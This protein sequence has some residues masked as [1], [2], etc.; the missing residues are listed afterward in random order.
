[1]R[2]LLQFPEGLKRHALE[3]AG[4]LE[5]D[6]NEVFLLARATYGACDLPSEEAKAL[7]ADK[8]VHFGHCRFGKSDIGIPV[9]YVPFG[10]RVDVAVLDGF[11][12]MLAE[13]GIAKIGI[14]TTAQHI[15]QLDEMKALFAKHGIDAI[16]KRGK[17]S[18]REGQVLGCDA[19]ALDIGVD[20]VAIV[21]DGMFHALAA[22]RLEGKSV[23]AVN[24]Y[25][26]KWKEIGNEINAIRKRERAALAIAYD[27]KV[28][29]ILVSTKG[30]QFGLAAAERAKRSIEKAGRKAYILV[31]NELRAQDIDNFMVFDAYI[32]SAC[33]RM[34]D[35]TA[36]FRKPM[37][38]I[39]MLKDLLE[40]WAPSNKQ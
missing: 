39:G 27:A 17:L 2:I 26:G 33:P 20:D 37:I 19:S 24:P 29:G 21:A 7:K 40:M 35:D 1:M 34:I 28:F 38:N 18:G 11:A 32:N 10:I 30:G 9:E 22:M 13:K 14:A 12:A 16:A 15:G 8:I 3:Y 5:R 4:R 31:S 25:S 6:G 23:Y 36:S